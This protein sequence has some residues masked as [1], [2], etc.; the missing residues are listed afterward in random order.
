MLPKRMRF[1]AFLPPVH[2]LRENPTL[3]FERDLDLAV[4]MDKLDFDEF[5]MGEHH[6]G[7]FEPVGNPE[8]FLMAA[9]ER[10]KNIRL[11][12]GV[13]TLPY[14]HPW[15]LADRINQLDHMTRG[16]AMFGMGPGAL[17]SDAHIQGIP[18]IE[19][20]DRYDEAMDVVVRLLRGETVTAK[21]EWFECNEARLHY[22]PY[23]RPSIEMV[24]TS[25]VSP[26]G[27]EAAGRHGLGMLAL[28]ATTTRG[29]N[30]LAASWEI[31]EDMARE[32]GQ[33]VDR[34]AWRLVG[35][36]HIAET[37]EKALEEVRFGI[38][39]W[40]Y[41]YREVANIPIIEKGVDPVEALLKTGM[42][43]IGTPD[44]VVERIK[45]LE[46]QSGGFGAFLIMDTNWATFEN[47]KKS[48]D[49]F[50]RYV[51]PKFQYSNEPRYESCAWIQEHREEF[52]SQARAGVGKRIQRHID[53]KGDANVNP[54]MVDIMKRHSKGE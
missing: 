44:D 20:R 49:L 31:A 3:T 1:G 14:H 40:V 22:T 54:M 12:T 26:T 7:G 50:A 37:R 29:F 45:Q 34:S 41:Y 18:P 16:R 2:S 15:M 46:E 5:W 11:G 47:K 38:D 30:A 35:P 8:I 52:V 39:D 42:A 33:T 25:N 53:E 24:A 13:C 43:V 27:P 28:G 48:Y 36:M 32:H 4:H 9:A 10:T 23:S 21:S 17:V 51:M 19:T 6:S